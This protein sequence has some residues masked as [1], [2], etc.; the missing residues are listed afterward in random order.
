MPKHRRIVVIGKQRAKLDP[1]LM[2]QVIIMLGRHL[3]EERQTTAKRKRAGA[4]K[5]QG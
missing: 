1:G 4:A 3:W 2:A 5:T